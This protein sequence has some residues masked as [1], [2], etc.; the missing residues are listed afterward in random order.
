MREGER[1]HRVDRHSW[2]VGRHPL[3]SVA[4]VVEVVTNARPIGR[5]YNMV[6]HP[7]IAAPFLTAADTVV[8][9]NGRRG[10]A[11]PKQC[12][13]AG[14]H[15]NMTGPCEPGALLYPS[16]IAGTNHSAGASIGETGLVAGQEVRHGPRARRRKGETRAPE[17]G[18]G[19]PA[20]NHRRHARAHTPRN[21]GCPACR[22][23][24]PHLHPR[25]AQLGVCVVAVK[26]VTS[27]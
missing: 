15:C 22:H 26:R 3:G 18:G 10:F 11:Q 13:D 8:D 1:R 5:V 17:P 21:L 27:G 16:A 23:F 19:F 6:Q 14:E 20:F 25:R 7:S 4:R 24:H 2:S 9:C 12:R